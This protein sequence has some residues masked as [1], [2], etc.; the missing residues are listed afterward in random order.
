MECPKCG[1]LQDDAEVCAA[2]GI[3]VDKY[4]RAVGVERPLSY[5]YVDNANSAAAFSRAR[6]ISG[7]V[8]GAVVLG[9]LWLFLVGGPG[10][11]ADRQQFAKVAEAMN[12]FGSM[13]ATTLQEHWMSNGKFPES[14]E[15]LGVP[16]PEDGAWPTFKRVSVTSDGR[17]VFEYQPPDATS[18]Q[19][20]TLVILNHPA[21]PPARWVRLCGGKNVRSGVRKMLSQM[22]A[23]DE[24]LSTYAPPQVA[25]KDQSRK[26]SGTYGPGYGPPAEREDEPKTA[27]AGYD[28]KLTPLMLALN[29]PDADEARRLLQTPGLEV[30]ARDADGNT[31]LMFASRNR[32][33]AMVRALLEAGADPALKNAAGRSAWFWGGVRRNVLGA[34]QQDDMPARLEV[35]ALLLARG[36]AVDQ[37]DES[38]ATLLLYAAGEGEVPLLEFLLDRGADLEARDKYGK[39]P[40]LRSVV[41][42]SDGAM[43][44]LLKRGA[45]VNSFDASGNT[46]I[47]LLQRQSAI[48]GAELETRYL[49]LRAAGAS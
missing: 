43:H 19:E 7:A 15:E 1:H 13:I 28:P 27:P 35:L 26:P 4:L 38:G 49:A 6:K 46:A 45:K 17:V 41:A 47:M 37:P 30:D 40:L 23:W 22:C 48:K 39:T 16:A 2:C 11:T 12:L 5:T 20:F 24:N 21:E 8:L 10:A 32:D 42:R 9:L 18:G 14:N 36:G 3:F 25:R 31:A 34:E 33:P 44:F 29:R